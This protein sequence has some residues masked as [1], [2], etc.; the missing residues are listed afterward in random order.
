VIKSRRI[1]SAEHVERMGEIRNSWKTV[2]GKHE[3][4]ETVW[5]TEGK[6]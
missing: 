2:V 4:E 6:W 1:I 5:E 3:K